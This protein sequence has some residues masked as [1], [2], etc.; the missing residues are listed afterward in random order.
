MSSVA[1]DRPFAALG[2]RL[3]GPLVD[4]WRAIPAGAD[5]DG[6]S[7]GRR[8]RAGR[9]RS[10]IT[11]HPLAQVPPGFGGPTLAATLSTLLRISQAEARRRLDEAEDLGPRTAMTGDR[12]RWCC[13]TG[14]RARRGDI[15]ADM[16]GSFA[17]FSPTARLVDIDTREAGEAQL[18]GSP[19][20]TPPTSYVK[21]PTGWH[22]CY[23][24]GQ[25]SDGDRARRRGLTIDKQGPDGMRDIS[26]TLDPEARATFEAVLAKWAAP[27]MCN[28]DD[29]SPWWTVSSP[30]GGDPDVGRRA[31]NHDAL[32]AASRAV[33]ASGELGSPTAY[34]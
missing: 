6:P 30:R 32:K 8:L 27:G 19:A 11:G 7:I 28:P 10:R 16:C 24:D 22:S 1:V 23:P 25:F 21:R 15:G 9:G 18:A 12:W 3:E 14:G 20:S 26:G 17:G 34:R 4:R 5:G 33:L 13:P 29:K 2:S 31:R